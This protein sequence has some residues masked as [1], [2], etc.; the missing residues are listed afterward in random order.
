[1]RCSEMLS[2]A[3][4]ETVGHCTSGIEKAVFP[5]TTHNR[6]HI[7]LGGTW[8]FSGKTA[9]CPTAT[10]GGRNVLLHFHDNVVMALR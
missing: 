3:W 8:G 2:G 7:N 4:L 9:Q 1:M 5:T 6:S 10:L